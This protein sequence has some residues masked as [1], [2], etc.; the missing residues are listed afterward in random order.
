MNY[1]I[2][3]MSQ[4]ETYCLYPRHEDSIFTTEHWTNKLSN[5]KTVTVLH[6]QQW[7]EGTFSI[8]LDETNKAKITDQKNIILNDWGA[9]TEELCSGWYY[10]TKIK[11][12]ES[13]NDEEKKEIH[14]L[15]YCD[16]DN[17]DAY[18][19]EE[20][21]EFEQDIM[22]ANDWSMDDTIYEIVNG[23]KLSIMSQM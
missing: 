1:I 23:C 13:F 9:C 11:N 7:N 3:K 6:V 4:M 21:Y 18:Y 15:M 2:S 20:E 5:G 12:E 8:E 16:K 14:K 10:K 22:E 19:S 17:E